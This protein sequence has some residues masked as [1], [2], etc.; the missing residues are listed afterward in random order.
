M[1]GNEIR[2]WQVNFEILSKLIFIFKGAVHVCVCV[3]VLVY[4]CMRVCVCV[5][6]YLPEN[7]DLVPTSYI[8][9]VDAPPNMDDRGLGS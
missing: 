9:T 2:Y 4:V 5:S 8:E 3:C 1:F 6:V 7:E